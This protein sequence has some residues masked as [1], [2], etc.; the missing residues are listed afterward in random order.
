MPTRRRSPTTSVPGAKIDVPSSRMSPSC[1]AP[2]VRSWRRL[3]E[4]RNVV[5][6][7]PEGPIR[8]VMA[9][10]G[11]AH[12]TSYRACVGPYQK[13][14]ARDSSTG[15]GLSDGLTVG[16]MGAFRSDRPTVRPSDTV[17]FNRIS[18]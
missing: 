14:Y 13:L 7:H 9:L 3:M 15:V 17:A 8:A 5:F 1:R 16:L 2:G 11:M 6:P 10:G 18:R 12:E 4:R